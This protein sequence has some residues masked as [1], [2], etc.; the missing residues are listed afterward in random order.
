M[1]TVQQHVEWVQ[2]QAHRAEEAINDQMEFVFRGWT[3]YRQVDHTFST[4][5]SLQIC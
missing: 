5:T 4:I 1:T 2:L 3:T